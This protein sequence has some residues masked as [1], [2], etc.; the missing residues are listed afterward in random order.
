MF[1]HYDSNIT[2]TAEKK[3]KKRAKNITFETFF[4]RRKKEKPKNLIGFKTLI[5][6]TKNLNCYFS[7]QRKSQK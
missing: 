7:D 2:N 3:G 1:L 6:L 4:S 5:C